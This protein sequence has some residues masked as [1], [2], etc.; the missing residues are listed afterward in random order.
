MIR[1]FEPRGAAERYEFISA[2]AIAE[3]AQ[4]QGTY[5]AWRA[6]KV[7]GMLQTRTVDHIALL[8]MDGL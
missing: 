4:E 2:E 3:S 1:T 6:K 5:V 8:F 7:V